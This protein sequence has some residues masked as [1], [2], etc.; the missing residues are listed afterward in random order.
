MNHT[1]NNHYQNIVT[2]T[3]RLQINKEIKRSGKYYKYIF[4]GRTYDQPRSNLMYYALGKELRDK[5]HKDVAVR[6]FLSLT[7]LEEQEHYLN[8]GQVYI[9]TWIHT[10]DLP[11]ISFSIRWANG[12]KRYSFIPR[13]NRV[14]DKESITE[15]V[16]AYINKHLMYAPGGYRNLQEGYCLPKKDFLKKYKM[17][18]QWH[19]ENKDEDRWR[20]DEIAKEAIR[21]RFNIVS[22]SLSPE[23]MIDYAKK[24]PAKVPTQV[25][26]YRL[27]DICCEG[28]I[29][30]VEDLFNEDLEEQSHKGK[31]V[32]V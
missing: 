9:H 19:K 18:Q 10:T 13:S 3:T 6:I 4:D 25:E 12:E 23:Q 17:I 15:L 30:E 8:I 5:G 21:K 1:F 29:D 22:N 32:L 16:I 7:S 27:P 26:K 31:V 28:D 2:N 14:I 24:H 11:T 20:R